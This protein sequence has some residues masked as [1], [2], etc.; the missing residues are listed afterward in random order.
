MW[1][2]GHRS[3]LCMGNPL[4]YL[5]LG[6]E[7]L[8]SALQGARGYDPRPLIC[9]DLYSLTQLDSVSFRYTYTA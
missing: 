7:A 1:R 6:T 5:T 2:V 8:G 9:L 3:A 4:V